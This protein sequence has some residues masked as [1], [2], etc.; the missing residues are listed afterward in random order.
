MHQPG[1]TEPSHT[2]NYAQFIIIKFNKKKVL[3]EHARD[4]TG[5]TLRTGGPTYQVRLTESTL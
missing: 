4:G 1:T 5:L 2:E 3:D